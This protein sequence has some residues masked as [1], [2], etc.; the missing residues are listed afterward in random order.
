[1][2]HGSAF[3]TPTRDLHETLT[4]YYSTNIDAMEAALKDLNLQ[5][6]KNISEVAN[7]HRVDRSTLSRRF[8]RVTNPA[9]VK[10]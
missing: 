9:K 2:L 5:D 8:N 10:H 4:R 7:L 3:C 1:M 6:K